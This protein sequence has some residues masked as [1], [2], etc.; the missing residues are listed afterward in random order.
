M[1]KSAVNWRR[2][3]PT[4]TI[5]GSFLLGNVAPS[6][7]GE[8]NDR[9]RL[10]AETW[11]TVDQLYMDR[12][13]NGQ[14]W[15]HLRQS[16]VKKTYDSDEAVYTAIKEMLNKLGDKY[17]RYLPPSQYET[18]MGSAQGQLIGIGVEL[19]TRE[20]GKIEILRV[21]SDS[22]AEKSGLRHGDILVK[23]DG[24]NALQLSAEQVGALLRG[25]EDSKVSLEVDRQGEE[26]S[27]NLQ[28][29][30]IRLQ[31]VQSQLLP[32]SIHGTTRKVFYIRIRSFDVNTKDD[33]IRAF[34][35]IHMKGSQID[36]LVI[37][38]RNNGG[39]VL[40]GAVDTAS[41]F[42]TPG[43]II[44]YVVGKDGLPEARQIAGSTLTSADTLLPDLT[45]PCFILIDGNTASAAEVF[46]AGLKENDRA[47][48][49]GEKSF[50]KGVIQTLQPLSQG[51]VAVTIARYET[52][53]H[54]NINKVGIEPDRTGH[55]ESSQEVSSCL[56]TLLSS[57]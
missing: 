20:D 50:G 25:K 9:N 19:G 10:A 29:Q 6:T 56:S 57:L 23:V 54:H 12:T 53:Q 28:R 31:G 21:E 7:A 40:Q 34:E 18:L 36:D 30:S 15:F 14:D 1:S 47:T 49:I 51:G 3:V 38:L 46:A 55:C 8:W 43:K 2:V 27:L 52:P 22:P 24:N 5:A 17:T 44:V 16:I 4:L 35:D 37:D 11:R 39:G 33:L 32:V 13:F 41:L 45:H 42:M 48:L 26:I